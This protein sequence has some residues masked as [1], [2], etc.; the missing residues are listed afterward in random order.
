MLYLI[1][2]TFGVFVIFWLGDL[3]ITLK[4]V[5]HLGHKAEINPIIRFILKSRGRFIY[6]FKIVEL[7]VFLYLIWF[8][9]SFEE[10]AHFYILLLFIL[11]YSLLVVNNA[12]VFYK[13]TG[14][15]SLFFKFVYLGLVVAMLLFIYLNYML[16]LDLGTSYEALSSSNERYSKLYWE[17]KKGNETVNAPLPH[18]LT[19]ILEDFNLPIRR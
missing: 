3:V 16:Y 14:K 1:L 2:I 7:G 9:F 5:K 11:L 18:D 6:I 10:T 15:E 4:T 17:C 8:L 13:A 19:T 12:H